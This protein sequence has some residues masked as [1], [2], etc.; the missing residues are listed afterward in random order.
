[1]MNR[2]KG[3]MVSLGILVTLFLLFVV[4]P[5]SAGDDWLPVSPEDLALKDNPKS[6]GTD[7][8]ILYRESVINSEHIFTDGVAVFEY[9]RVKIFTKG[10]TKEGDVEIPFVKKSFD[11]WSAPS[12]GAFDIGDV[13]GRTIRPDGSIVNFD[14]KV[15]ERSISKSGRRK[16]LAKTFT[17]PDVE[18]GCIIEYRFRRQYGPFWFVG[19]EWVL[20]SHLFTREA[21]FTMSPYTSAG[22]DEF[23]VIY[24]YLH[25]QAPV[26]PEE[27][28][29]TMG[30]RTY[31]SYSLAVHDVPGIEEEP[32]MPPE[33]A[34][35]QRIAFY[36]RGASEPANETPDQYWNR[37]GKKWNGDLDRF[38]NKQSALNGELSQIISSSDSPESKLRKIYARVQQIRNLDMEEAKTEQ[39]KK[40][41]DIKTNSNIADVLKHGYGHSRD[42]N[43]LFVGLVRAAGFDA[44]E[45]FVAPRNQDTFQP[46]TK[47]SDRLSD[48]LVWVKAGTQEYYLDPSARYFP[49]GVL[50]WPESA[51]PGIR[52]NKQGSTMITTPPPPS[53]DAMIIRHADLEMDTDGSVF[54]KLQIDLTGQRG[55][56]LRDENHKQDE[57]GRKKVLEEEIRGWLPAGSTL[58]VTKIDNWGNVELPV[59]V[60]GAVN[61]PGFGT[62]AGRRMLVPITIFQAPEAKM[63]H[64]EK[65]TNNILFPYPYQE[66]D[67]VKFKVPAGY[68]IEAV[69]PAIPSTPAVITYEVAATQQGDAVEVKR[70]FDERGIMFDVKYYLAL[71]AFFN[72]VK[73]NDDAQILFQKFDSSK[74]N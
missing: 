55:A 24:A 34:L 41:E 33:G 58:E 72:V 22:S 18:P 48:G 50:P 51:S 68:R 13:R 71:R 39:E 45:V 17:M 25:L 16:Y 11:Y 32:L 61:V 20:S 15:Y 35:Q 70:H 26:K 10:G 14:G 23:N 40:Q 73:S 65:R 1:V 66:T 38:I 64:A 57:T 3:I 60:E 43:R 30:G 49:F 9:V 44:T 31:T 42:I 28:T 46:R 21:H 53:S 36:Y 54:G 2:T 63:F 5:V 37:I 56:L 27:R 12:A 7:A 19:Q 4:R 67:D 59:H 74:S 8:M 62:T 29:F 47:D 6:P 69:P 52:I